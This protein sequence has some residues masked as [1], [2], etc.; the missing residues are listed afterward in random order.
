MSVFGNV[1]ERRILDSSRSH[2]FLWT[3]A[4]GTGADAAG[5][6]QCGYQFVRVNVAAPPVVMREPSVLFITPQAQPRDL[7][8]AMCKGLPAALQASASLSLFPVLHHVWEMCSP[9][10]A[11]GALLCGDELGLHDLPSLPIGETLWLQAE[12][13]QAVAL[14]AVEDG[15]G[16]L[17]LIAQALVHAQER[18][19]RSL[20]CGDVEGPS[21]D[22]LMA[23]TAA[24]GQ[25]DMVLAKAISS[26]EAARAY[27]Q[28]R[29][30]P[31]SSAAMPSVQAA[32]ALTAPPPP[33]TLATSDIEGAS[34]D[35]QHIMAAAARVETNMRCLRLPS[36]P[37][38]P[39]L[40]RRPMRPRATQT[41]A[42]PASAALMRADTPSMPSLLLET[43]CT[44]QAL[45]P[46]I[47]ALAALNEIDRGARGGGAL[48]SAISTPFEAVVDDAFDGAGNL[49]HSADDVLCCGYTGRVGRWG[50]QACY[51]H[52]QRAAAGD[53]SGIIVEW[54]NQEE[55]QGLP[56]VRCDC[57]ARS[58]PPSSRLHRLLPE[59]ECC[60]SLGTFFCSP[61]PLGLSMSLSS[62]PARRTSGW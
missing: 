19:R 44:A 17:A 46:E 36:L 54:L 35:I 47:L 4:R 37:P 60:L 18:E 3:P 27:Q 28:T 30:L 43:T 32:H 38:P 56:Y 61:L 31:S 59:P 50:E 49:P 6:T 11:L 8:V 16:A 26:R 13:P 2:A 20:A 7:I 21:A 39:P 10:S 40:P 58:L 9:T 62:R 42:E 41:R 51:E 52:L 25:L 55:E 5:N 24:D 45:N 57:A 12:S 34:G 48:R 53:D 33:T 22:L 1:L 15:G 29:A 23:A 14:Q